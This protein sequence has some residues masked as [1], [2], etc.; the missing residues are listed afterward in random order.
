[1]TYTALATLI[2][3]GDDLSQLNRT[4]IS[5]GLRKMQKSDGSFTASFES[6]ESDMRFVYCA[7]TVAFMIDDWSGVDKDSAVA[8][9]MASLRYQSNVIADTVVYAVWW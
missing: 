5:Q 9:I 1:M 8:F 3:L 2:T 7:C 6:S 4:L